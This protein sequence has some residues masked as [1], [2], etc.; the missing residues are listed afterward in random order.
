MNAIINQKYDINKID[1]SQGKWT[2]FTAIAIGR[3]E[4]PP[5]I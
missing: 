5:G 4:K 1:P 3:S 2:L